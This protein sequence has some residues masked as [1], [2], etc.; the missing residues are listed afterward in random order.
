MVMVT[1]LPRHVTRLIMFRLLTA[2]ASTAKNGMHSTVQS[3][4]TLVPDPRY[5]GM[6]SASDGTCWQLIAA[7]A[8]TITCTE[9]CTCAMAVLHL[10]RNNSVRPEQCVGLCISS[11]LAKLSKQVRQLTAGD[12]NQR[13]NTRMAVCLSLDKCY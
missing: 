8:V 10:A 9:N 13:R 12:S 5:M 4:P 11:S 2:S 7:L 1:L 3:Q 6:L